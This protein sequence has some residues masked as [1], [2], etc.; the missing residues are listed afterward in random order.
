VTNKDSATAVTPRWGSHRF[1]VRTAV[2]DM[3]RVTAAQV[4]P[5]IAR[6][7]HERNVARIDVPL[8]NSLTIDPYTDSFV[9]RVAAEVQALRDERAI[10]DLKEIT[11]RVTLAYRSRSKACLVDSVP[12][13]R[14]SPFV[15]ADVQVHTRILTRW[16][17]MWSDRDLQV[18]W[19]AD[20]HGVYATP[21][22]STGVEPIRGQAC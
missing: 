3:A 2:D 15:V 19:P 16:V 12:V 13:P 9:S 5:D 17:D 20:E 11:V 1:L 10:P 6:Y 22:T 21:T 8:V 7:L 18:E 4:T 14:R